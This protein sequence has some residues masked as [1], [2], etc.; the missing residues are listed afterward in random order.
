MYV[1]S[2]ERETMSPMAK[3]MS[4]SVGNPGFAIKELGSSEQIKFL[5]FHV[6]IHKDTKTK[7]VRMLREETLA[8]KDGHW[9]G[10]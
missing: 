10:L 2:H 1:L 7:A 6:L 8:M 5:H 4:S 3:N 9:L